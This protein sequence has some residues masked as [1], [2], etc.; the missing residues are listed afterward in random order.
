MFLLTKQYAT[1][2]PFQQIMIFPSLSDLDMLC[3]YEDEEN[4]PKLV[5]PPSSDDLLI[6][7]ETL[8]PCLSVYEVKLMELFKISP[9]ISNCNCEMGTTFFGVSVFSFNVCSIYIPVFYVFWC[10][11]QA[12]EL[13]ICNN[14]MYNSQQAKIQAQGFFSG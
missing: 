6:S 2:L 12:L 5:L 1:Y 10:F 7:N 3:D 14:N 11:T 9:L 8:L 13:T 4:K